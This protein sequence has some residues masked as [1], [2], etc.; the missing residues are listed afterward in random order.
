MPDFLFYVFNE[1]KWIETEKLYP[2]DIALILDIKEK[3]I[4]LW[5]GHR[6]TKSMKVE[7]LENYGILISK[8]PNFKFIELDDAVPIKIQSQI[9]KR[10]DL[11][12][13][14]AKKIERTP[15]YFLF[16]VIGIVGLASLIVSVVFM[17]IPLSWDKSTEYTAYYLV[18]EA[19]YTSW[20]ENSQISLIVAI[21]IFEILLI[22]S[23]FTKKIFLIMAAGASSLIT[24]GFYKYIS[25]GIYLFDFNP[26]EVV[27]N[28]LIMQAEIYWHFLLIMGGMVAILLPILISINAILKETFP[29]SFK[30]WR[31]KKRKPRIVLEKFSII[32]RESSFIN[33]KGKSSP[34]ELIPSEELVQK[35]RKRH[36]RDI[37]I[38]LKPLD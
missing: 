24:I 9:D 19:N 16:L 13:E 29:I 30:E 22:D 32:S 37:K 36:K 10:L 18:S 15:A 3:T 14:Q 8:Y 28:Y 4:Y 12:F 38:E 6:A 27:G 21:I 20:V 23:I 17:L 2:H 1:G 25:L 33:E 34:N 11:T 7:A 5:I 26:G 35:K 31:A